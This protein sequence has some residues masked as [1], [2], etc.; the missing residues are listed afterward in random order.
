MIS[1]IRARYIY[2]CRGFSDLTIF[3]WE[4]SNLPELLVSASS[5]FIE[6]QYAILDEVLDIND[7][8]VI[9]EELKSLKSSMTPNC[10]FIWNPATRAN[11]LYQKSHIIEY[12]YY[13]ESI[14]KGAPT[15]KQL[16]DLLAGDTLLCRMLNII[17]GKDILISRSDEVDVKDVK[18]VLMQQALKVQC[19]KGNGGCFPIHFDSEPSVDS[20]FLTC[21][22]YLNHPEEIQG[23][24]LELYPY[25][26]DVV[27]IEPLF[28]RMV[29]FKSLSMA[30]RV[31]P[32]FSERYCLTVWCSTAPR[33]NKIDTKYDIKH[34]IG[35]YLEEIDQQKKESIKNYILKIPE[36][37][38]HVLK[39]SNQKAWR[40]SIQESH[41]N[42][43]K[44]A[45]LLEM[46]DREIETIKRALG[47][48][49][50]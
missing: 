37:R 9:R 35:Y 27:K 22:L 40:R 29:I 36:I 42:S 21:I 15:G 39:F 23:G 11:V 44:N 41:D 4:R 1:Q 7:A 49:L 33:E 31:L 32:S 14:S 6:E 17:W 2:I 18:N 30:H 45:Q 24:E 47:P 13:S 16:L 25:K 19:N 34:L 5:H 3:P 46:F 50:D 12:D 10:T 48:I 43:E 26:S 8:L 38:R 20:R 28:N